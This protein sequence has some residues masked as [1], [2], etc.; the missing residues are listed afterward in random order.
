[1]DDTVVAQDPPRQARERG[2]APFT[3][4]EGRAAFGGGGEWHPRGR[5][6][7]STFGGNGGGHG[8]WVFPEAYIA[9]TRPPPC[10]PVW[11]MHNQVAIDALAAAD[12]VVLPLAGSEGKVKG[13]LDMLAAAPGKRTVIGIS[14]VTTW[15]RTAMNTAGDPLTERDEARRGVVPGAAKVTA[16]AERVILRAARPGTLEAR[17]SLL[18]HTVPVHTRR[19]LF[20]C[21]T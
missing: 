9:L 20:P 7:L 16:D 10:C 21:L 8:A 11:Q 19:I 2:S 15:A 3:F 13:I 5:G 1:M 14:S 4:G 18:A 17:P 12:V 6:R